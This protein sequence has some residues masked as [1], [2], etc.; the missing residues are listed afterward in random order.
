MLKF[1]MELLISIVDPSV[2]SPPANQSNLA[3]FMMMF[4]V[5]TIEVVFMKI[6]TAFADDYDLSA[7]N[8]QLL[9][10]NFFNRPYGNI[11]RGNDHPQYTQGMNW[12]D[13]NGTEDEEATGYSNGGPDEHE[14][15][16]INQTGAT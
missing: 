5:C 8:S 9:Y 15:S 13:S 3:V 2:L 11:Y 4:M 12:I 6:V 14:T 7:V 1:P 10:S 16:F